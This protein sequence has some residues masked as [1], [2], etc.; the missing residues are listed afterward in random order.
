MAYNECHWLF[1]SQSFSGVQ[2]LAICR[3]SLRKA[4]CDLSLNDG[5]VYLLPLVSYASARLISEGL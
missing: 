5:N 4:I 1:L 2:S 3:L